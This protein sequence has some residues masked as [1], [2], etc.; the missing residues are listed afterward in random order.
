M[1]CRV[2]ATCVSV[3]HFLLLLERTAVVIVAGKGSAAEWLVGIKMIVKNERKYR[4][5]CVVVKLRAKCF[6]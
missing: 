5:L 2:L 3:C 4:F 1:G 6:G